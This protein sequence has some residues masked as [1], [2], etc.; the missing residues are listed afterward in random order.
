M[1]PTLAAV[2]MAGITE[3]QPGL[4]RLRNRIRQVRAGWQW[5]LFVLLGIP[6]LACGPNA[7]W[8]M[9]VPMAAWVT[10]APG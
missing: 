6:A 2:L 9:R 7:L 1:G 8:V 3:G 4:R 10:C 5:Y